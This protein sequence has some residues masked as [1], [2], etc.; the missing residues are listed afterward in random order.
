MTTVRFWYDVVCPYAYL[1]STQVA[2]L[3]ESLGFE[4]EWAPMLLGGVFRHHGAPQVPASAMSPSKA[5]MN[6]L[7]L[8]RWAQRWG[9]PFSFSHRHP[10]RT[11][12][13][14]RLLCITPQALIPKVS[15][16]L[17][18]VYW[19]EQR[20]LDEQ[21]L[22]EACVLAGLEPGAWQQ[23][24]AKAS[25]F[26]R[27]ARA[28]EL[29]VFGVPT[30]EVVTG[31]G[32]HSHTELFW[33]Q[34]RLDHVKEACGVPRAPLTPCLAPEGSE[35]IFYHDLASPFSYLAATQVERVV[36]LTGA[37]L[38][39]R[40]MLLGALFKSIGAPNVPL[41][42]M[43]TPKRAYMGQ[44]LSRWARWWG[45]P[46][47]QPKAF[48]L[49]TPTVLRLCLLEPRLTLPLYHAAWGEGRDIGDDH[50]LLEL[51]APLCD[52]LSLPHTPAELLKASREPAIKEQLRVNTAE[53]EARGVFG[54]PTFEV[55]RSGEPPV[56]LWGQDRLEQLYHALTSPTPLIANLSQCEPS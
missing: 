36:A 44:E 38:T 26:E 29:G 31:E 47:Q 40:P 1:A 51:L 8:Y 6:S 37:R 15:A 34:D 52:A 54:A 39:W 7:E 14:M 49:R 18:N 45:V 23:E 50:T 12:E 25:L 56:L 19:A 21:A 43:S 42:E 53:A 48:P 41:F 17:F 4:V 20:P 33:G 2:Q 11:V 5:E 9:V 27:T 46:F 13:A 16:H 28:A 24:E 32:D 55:R 35:V 22:E 10:Q 30:F 3:S